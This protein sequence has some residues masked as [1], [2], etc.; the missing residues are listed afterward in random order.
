MNHLKFSNMFSILTASWIMKKWHFIFRCIFLTPTV[1]IVVYGY[2]VSHH[3][4]QYYICIVAASFT[5]GVPGE[6][7]LQQVTDKLYHIKK[8]MAFQ[9][10]DF[11]CTWLWL[12]QKHVV[13]IK[14][15][16]YVFIVVSS[17]PR[18]ERL[19]ITPK[20]VNYKKGIS[21]F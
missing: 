1:P 19:T 20:L 7:H 21:D 14:F 10:F 18:H 15:D 12:F 3:F 11:E 6:N 16:I 8:R 13:C 17:T 4:P 2:G 5:G 9:Y